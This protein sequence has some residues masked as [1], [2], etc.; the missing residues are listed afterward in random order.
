MSMMTAF[1]AAQAKASVQAPTPAAMPPPSVPATRLVNFPLPPPA[2]ELRRFLEDFRRV[3]GIDITAC[4][5][6]FEQSALTPDIIPYLTVARITEL[7]GLLE[8]HAVKLQM[9]G[10][11]WVTS[12]EEQRLAHGFD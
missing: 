8:G 4:I 5:P 6:I 1:F 9:F 3:K 2:E 10:K 11:E 7:G 12:L